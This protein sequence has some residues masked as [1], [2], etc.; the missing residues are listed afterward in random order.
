MTV[1][2][3][4]WLDYI[5]DARDELLGAGVEV[6]PEMVVEY[7]RTMPG[8][9]GAE[10][11]VAFDLGQRQSRRLASAALRDS[12]SLPVDPDQMPL[13]DGIDYQPPRSITKR[14][15]GGKIVHKG[16]MHA[17]PAD[18]HAYDDILTGNIDAA[19]NRRRAWRTFAETIRPWWHGERTVADALTIRAEGE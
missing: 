17:T 2:E 1:K 15:E 9:A 19:V 5:N 3:R 16:V 11:E 13:F 18:G 6:D 14:A 10:E 12:E 4:T 8:G 7:A